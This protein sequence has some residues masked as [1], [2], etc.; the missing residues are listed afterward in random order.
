[1]KYIA[2][3]IDTIQSVDSEKLLEEISTQAIKYNRVIKVLL[4]VKIAEE[5]TKSGL[6]LHEAKELFQRYLQGDFA[7]LKLQV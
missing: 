5:E 2:E 4:Q 6:E 7:M 3:F 1:M